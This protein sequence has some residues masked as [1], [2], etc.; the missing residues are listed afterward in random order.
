MSTREPWWALYYRDMILKTERFDTERDAVMFLHELDDGAPVAVHGPNGYKFEQSAIRRRARQFWKAENPAEAEAERRADEE[1]RRQQ[2]AEQ[3]R[4]EAWLAEQPDWYRAEVSS[5]RIT[6][7]DGLHRVEIN[8]QPLPFRVRSVELQHDETTWG[9]DALD[10]PAL[11]LH[12]DYAASTRIDYGA[13][14]TRK[15]PQ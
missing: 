5:I 9:P 2:Q 7:V 1:R 14:E 10:M 6:P 4:Y 15:A 12:L 8:G 3:E 11:V 13:A